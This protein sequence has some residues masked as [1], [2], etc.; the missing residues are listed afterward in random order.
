MPETLSATSNPADLI[1]ARDNTHNLVYFPF[2]GLVGCIR[3]TMIISGEPYKFTTLRFPEWRV[4]KD[5]TPFGHVPVLREETK[6]GKTIELAEISTIEQFLASRAG[7]LGKDFWE[8]NLVKMYL[9]STHA[10]FSFL[11]HNVVQS[12]KEERPAFLERF[13]TRS[14]TE[15]IKFH[16]KHLRANGAN[17]HYVGDQL[18]IADIKTA[19][20][21]EHLVRL[22]G[23]NVLISEELTPAIMAVKNNVEKNPAYK[24]WRSSEQYQAFT[25][26]NINFFGL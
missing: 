19:S 12:P 26:A 17:G 16:E 18:S 1:Q 2:H 11:I 5:S 24:E 6:C 21:I 20:V 15:W 25:A 7:L 3:T 4:Q 10:L 8:E 14:L 22:C 9:S 13:R 23:D